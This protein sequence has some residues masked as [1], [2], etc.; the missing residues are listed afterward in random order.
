MPDSS[1]QATE[2]LRRVL[3]A[4]RGGAPAGVPSVCSAEPFVLRA[5]LDQALAAG[6]VALVESTCNQVNQA[7]G[8]T[9]VTPAGFAAQVRDLAAAGG[10]PPD[11]LVLGGDH[12]G[13]YPWRA[14]P[15]GTAM[16]KARQLV[17]ACVLAGYTKIHLDPSV[18]LGGDAH[19]LDERVVLAR[20]VELCGA[21]EE[22][23]AELP[24]DAPGPLYVIGTEVPRPGGEQ[25]D[26][27]GPAPTRADDVRGFLGRAAEAFAAAGLEDAW[28]RVVAVVVQPGVEFDTWTVHRYDRVKARALP[29]ALEDVPG[30]VY[31]AHS[32]DYQTEDALRALVH[33]RFAVLKVGPALTFAFREALFALEAI[34]TDVVGS[35]VEQ[36]HLRETLDTAMRADPSYWRDYYRGAETEVARARLFSLSDR[37]RYY[38]PRPEVRG[39]LDRLLRNLSARPIP[40]MVL[41]ECLPAQAEA[42]RSGQLEAS[43]EPLIRH[44]IGAVL[45]QY[46]AACGAS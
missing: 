5:A 8:Y 18:P 16:A 22:A 19:P 36:S 7:G 20:T 45:A 30:L 35:G 10:L 14:E 4:N 41:D 33:D 23:S 37:C 12:L 28:R 40:L 46:W 39:A 15:A 21:A 27:E 31:E 44:A 26:D 13:P 11:H 32:T 3:I 43:P 9:G 42:V 38:W 34:E 1:A 24:G 29:A 17:R 2:R 6:G 25:A